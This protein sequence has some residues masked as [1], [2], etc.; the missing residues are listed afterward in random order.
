MNKTTPSDQHHAAYTEVADIFD[1]SESWL[2]GHFER[3]GQSLAM[4]RWIV[5]SQPTRRVMRERI[6]EVKDAA[7]QL[8][9]RLGDN[10]IV[11]FLADA[12]QLQFLNLGALLITL[13][14][15]ATHADVAMSSLINEDGKTK[16]GRGKALVVGAI[17]PELYCALIVAETW[18]FLFGRYPD[19]KTRKAALVAECFWRASGGDQSTPF[20]NEPNG[21]RPLG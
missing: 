20:G 14:T 9:Q 4:H 7:L 2:A 3:W 15:I 21:S 6:S 12:S 11:T 17:T 5:K 13:T 18:N 8:E 16:S 19:P 1:S 10:T